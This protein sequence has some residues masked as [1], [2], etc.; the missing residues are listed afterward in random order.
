MYIYMYTYIHIYVYMYKNTYTYTYPCVSI[1]MHTHKRTHTHIRIRIYIHV[2]PD[3]CIHLDMRKRSVSVRPCC[4]SFFHA[5][6]RKD[7]VKTLCLRGR[8]LCS[9][10]HTHVCSP[11]QTHVPLTMSCMYALPLKHTSPS[12]CL[13]LCSP[14]Q[15][16]CLFERESIHAR[17]CVWEGEHT[18]VCVWVLAHACVHVCV[19]V[20][21]LSWSLSFSIAVLSLPVDWHTCTALAVCCS[22]LQCVAV[23]CNSVLQCVAVCC[24][25]LQ[26]V[27]IVCC[28]GL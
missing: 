25:V 7:I 24:S 17:H 2:L 5:R 20:H 12:Q 6:E 19:Y 26:C 28:S 9:H 15:T 10:T 16:Q 8:A 18:C 23:C 1:Y 21:V 3:T 11:S 13:A 4:S 22:V 27:A 14:S